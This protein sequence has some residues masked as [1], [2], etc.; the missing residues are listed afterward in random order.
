MQSAVFG[1]S[2]VFLKELLFIP[3]QW[4]IAS[5]HFNPKRDLLVIEVTGKNLPAARRLE[6]RITTDE[7]GRPQCATW[8]DA[9]KPQMATEQT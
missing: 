8:R 9:D 5:I 2:L 3:K 4:E 1:M 6:C 7:D